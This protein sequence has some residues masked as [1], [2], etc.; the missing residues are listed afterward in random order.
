MFART[1]MSIPIRVMSLPIESLALLL[2]VLLVLAVVLAARRALTLFVVEIRNGHI[3]RA[4]GR[5]PPSLLNDFLVVCPPGHDHR[6]IISC[7]IEQGRARLTARGPV[8][9]DSLQQLRNLVGL[10]PLPRLKSAP[11]VRI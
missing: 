1:S 9:G 8:T 7:R 10:W 2:P 11:R 3:V 6:I 4:T 5:I